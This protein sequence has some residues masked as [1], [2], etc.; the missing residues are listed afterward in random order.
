MKQTPAE[1]E[2]LPALAREA[3]TIVAAALETA[4]WR[5]APARRAENF[6]DFQRSHLDVG[7]RV[8]VPGGCWGTLLRLMRGICI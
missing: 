6:Y 5:T 7:R 2:P 4:E 3:A 1:S 8:E